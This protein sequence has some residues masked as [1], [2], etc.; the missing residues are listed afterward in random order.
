MKTEV[1]VITSEDQKQAPIHQYG[2]F[3]K[4]GPDQLYQLIRLLDRPSGTEINLIAQPEAETIL[5]KPLIVENPNDITELE[6]R[7][8]CTMCGVDLELVKNVTITIG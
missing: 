7:N 2:N 4:C 5:T 1:K 6:F 8:L 3:Y